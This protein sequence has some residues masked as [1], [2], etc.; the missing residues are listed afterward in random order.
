MKE[1]VVHVHFSY[2]HGLNPHI[3]INASLKPNKIPLV[4]HGLDVDSW[5]EAQGGK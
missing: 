4:K 3:T 1:K 2:K 5:G